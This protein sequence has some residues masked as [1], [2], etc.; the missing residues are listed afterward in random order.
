MRKVAGLYQTNTAS[1][2]WGWAK[3]IDVNDLNENGQNTDAV[4][5]VAPTNTSSCSITSQ[6]A[7]INIKDKVTVTSEGVTGQETDKIAL[8][9][10]EDIITYTIE[11]ENESAGK[12]EN[13]SYYIPIPKSNSGKD[14]FIQNQT[15]NG[16]FD[17]SMIEAPKFEG[18]DLF[19]VT[20][21]FQTGL[22]YNT[23]QQVQASEWYTKEQIEANPS[24]KWEN[25]TMIKFTGKNVQINNGDQSKMT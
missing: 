17:L 3:S 24:L 15:K 21:T 25:V 23:A 6:N 8:K 16:G 11:F 4:G 2:S 10:P 1:G 12:A 9:T 19:N 7:T 5:G 13:F 14:S 18:D 22:T 20:Y